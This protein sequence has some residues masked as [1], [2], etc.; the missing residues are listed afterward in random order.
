LGAALI[1]TDANAGVAY[2]SSHRNYQQRGASIDG[3]VV[4]DY[5]LSFGGLPCAPSPEAGRERGRN[6]QRSN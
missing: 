3:L 6:I 4:S 1:E 5:H 2:H